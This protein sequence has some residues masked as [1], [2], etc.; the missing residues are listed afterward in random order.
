VTSPN[1][2]GESTVTQENGARHAPPVP[3]RTPVNH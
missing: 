3:M 2:A 1:V